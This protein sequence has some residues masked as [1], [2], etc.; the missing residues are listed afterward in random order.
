L[1]EELDANDHLLATMINSFRVLALV[2]EDASSLQVSRP[3][4][5]LLKKLT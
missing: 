4:G 1:K 2:L 5:D 3:S